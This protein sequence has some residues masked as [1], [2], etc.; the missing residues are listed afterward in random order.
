MS[1]MPA[2]RRH[3]IYHPRVAL[4]LLLVGAV[5]VATGVV[6]GRHF[7]PHASAPGPSPTRTAVVS[8]G[9]PPASL[10]TNSGSNELTALAADFAQLQS[11]LHAEIGIAVSA[12]GSAASPST[13]GDW[14]TGPAW[15]TIKVPLAIAALRQENPP[16]VTAAMKA[17]ITESDNAA[18]ESIWEGMG[19][20]VIAAH[21]VE[22]VLKEA[23]DSTTVQSQKV[24]PEF[25]AFGQTYWPLV[26][27]A[28][29]LA[30]AKCDSQNE[31]IFSLM[32]EVE[33]D[34]RWGMGTIPDAQIKG[35]WGPS[36]S[37]S[38]LV[39]QI[40]ILST[41]TGVIAVAMAA[42]PASGSFADGTHDL[43]E[44]ANW[45][46]AHTAAMPAGHCGS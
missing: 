11:Q 38:Y 9:T 3:S 27:Q 32:G 34:Q 23:G 41:S 25:T 14:Q 5:I 16:Q 18:A 37:G 7:S 43:T 24:R 45:L 46:T 15:S 10:P 13:L 12:V 21:R 29:F 19:D 28:R 2:R 31:P 1:G 33:Q 42:Q 26:D 17:A 39:R 44:V 30:F 22:D 8:P 35:G 36:T 20:P 40:G 4:A 6:I